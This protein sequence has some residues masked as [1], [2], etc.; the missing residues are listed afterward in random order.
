[1]AEVLQTQKDSFDQLVNSQTISKR[2]REIMTVFKKHQTVGLTLFELQKILG[3]PINSIS[4]RITELK[5][6]GYLEAS[7]RCRRNPATNKSATVWKLG[8]L[9]FSSFSED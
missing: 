7:D 2:H 9:F 8:N 5:T 1:M 6:K 3:W 4:G